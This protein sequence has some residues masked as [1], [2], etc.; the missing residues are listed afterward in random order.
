M[1]RS[2]ALSAWITESLRSSRKWRSLLV[3]RSLAEL[4]T[5]NLSVAI[6]VSSTHAT[7]FGAAKDQRYARHFQ[8]QRVLRIH[9]SLPFM[10]HAYICSFLAYHKHNAYINQCSI[11]V[12][13]LFISVK[14]TAINYRPGLDLRMKSPPYVTA[15]TYAV[16][17][18]NGTF[19]LMHFCYQDLQ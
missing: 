7:C 12:R 9:H 1:S 8:E 2:V 16:R 17:N 6:S 3:E 10:V 11:Y 18:T 19:V 14:S 5:F 4:L 15:C 13:K